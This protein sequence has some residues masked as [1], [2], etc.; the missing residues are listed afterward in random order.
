MFS[1]KPVQLERC[2]DCSRVRAKVKRG[3]LIKA[4][5]HRILPT[6]THEP[7]KPNSATECTNI[8]SFFLKQQQ[9]THVK[10][11]AQPRIE[12]RARAQRTRTNTNTD[13]HSTHAQGI[14]D[15]AAVLIT[16]NGSIRRTVMINPAESLPP[17]S[18][19]CR[20][21]AR[22]LQPCLH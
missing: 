8:Y 20:A 10:V 4:D 21:A 22:L 16:P 5:V 19:T 18:V 14:R 17:H 9:L 6:K 1:C 3:G 13:T 12:C 2:S 7:D 11:T 15:S